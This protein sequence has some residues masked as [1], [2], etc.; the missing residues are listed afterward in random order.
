MD[1]HCYHIHKA[2]TFVF[3]IVDLLYAFYALL[4]QRHYQQDASIK[5]F[6][7]ANEEQQQNPACA[8]TVVLIHQRATSIS[9]C[10]E[11]FHKHITVRRAFFAINSNKTSYTPSMVLNYH[12]NFLFYFFSYY[13]SS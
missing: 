4:Y 10:D 2:Y 12:F 13:F 9:R 7:T 6:F 1:R 8:I 5:Q 3:V 11:G